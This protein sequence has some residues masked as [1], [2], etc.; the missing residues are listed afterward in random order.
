V[1]LFEFAARR[2]KAFV[3]KHYAVDWERTAGQQ[4]VLAAIFQA[5]VHRLVVNFVEPTAN[6][7]DVDPMQ[8]AAFQLGQGLA[9][10]ESDMPRQRGFG[11]GA[12]LP[13]NRHAATV[14]GTTYSNSQRRFVTFL[15]AFL[16]LER[17]GT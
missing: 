2:E 16:G 10:P 8:V 11:H 4:V 6:L 13:R 1:R 17:N 5:G 3:G 12:I 15:T 7:F 14:P 9:D